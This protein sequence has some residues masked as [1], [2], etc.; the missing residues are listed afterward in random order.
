MWLAQRQQPSARQEPPRGQRLT[1]SGPSVRVEEEERSPELPEVPPVPRLSPGDGGGRAGGLAPL[2]PQ[3][4]GLQGG[5]SQ[6]DLQDHVF[7]G[8]DVKGARGS[9]I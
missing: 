3:G 9:V 5:A 6:P 8:P 7:C 2:C 1:G 4:P